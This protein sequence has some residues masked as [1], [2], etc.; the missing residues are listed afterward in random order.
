MLQLMYVITII[1]SLLSQLPFVLKSG[2]DSYFKLCW[3]PLTIFILFKYPKSVFDRKLLFFYLFI[4][5]FGIYCFVAQTFSGKSYLEGGSDYYNIII[6]FVVFI[7]SCLFWKYNHSVKFYKTIVLTIL[8]GCII[9]SFYVYRDYLSTDDITQRSYAY[10]AKNSLGQILFSCA[11]ISFLSLKLF[12]SRISK[13]FFIGTILYLFVIIMLLKSR[14]TIIG[15]FF[16]IVY[17][18]AKYGSVKQR[19]ITS[20]IVLS[21]VAFIL[22]NH[23]AYEI[24]VENIIFANRNAESMDSLSSGRVGLIF[25]ALS[26][27]NKRFWF[28][29]GHAYVDCMPVCV[30]MQYGIFGLIII[31]TFLAVLARKVFKFNRLEIV[32]LTSFLLFLTYMINSL[33]EAYP[34]FGPGIKCFPLWMMLGFSFASLNFK[35]RIETQRDERE[36]LCN[37]K[38]GPTLS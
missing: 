4:L 15:L 34:P 22:L 19:I 36:N 13:V 11:L 26:V 30:W 25:K 5:I 7:N 31:F 20:T 17:M 1:L 27:I 14:A 10:G 16:V 35:Y 38:Y 8:I 24:V 21:I 23:D 12:K 37:I 9:L 28:G 32:N 2:L 3:I 29:N 33:F 6:S 18:L